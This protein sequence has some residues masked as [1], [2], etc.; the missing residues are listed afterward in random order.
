MHADGISQWSICTVM[1][2]VHLAIH[3]WKH[4][5]WTDGA[6][7]RYCNRNVLATAMCWQPQH[8]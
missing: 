6:A 1:Q 4:A 7:A 3:A 2:H 5:A 8:Y